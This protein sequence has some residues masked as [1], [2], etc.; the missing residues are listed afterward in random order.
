MWW[1]GND[2]E[3]RGHRVRVE[4]GGAVFWNGMVT[5]TASTQLRG[6]PGLGSGPGQ[7]SCSFSF[8]EAVLEVEVD[9]EGSNVMSVLAERGGKERTYARTMNGPIRTTAGRT[10]AHIQ[11]PAR[12]SATPTVTE[13]VGSIEPACG[14]HNRDQ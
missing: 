3:V 8:E 11:G 12:S 10:T 9:P 7:D 14:D 13:E 4:V 2:T 5:R 1:A 6:K